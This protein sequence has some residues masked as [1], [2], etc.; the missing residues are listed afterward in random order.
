M[1]IVSPCFLM[2]FSNYIKQ[3][4]YFSYHRTFINKHFLSDL[5]LIQTNGQYEFHDHNIVSLPKDKEYWNVTVSVTAE[6]DAYIVLCEGRDPFSS[7][8]YWIILGG[9]Y[10]QIERCVIRRCPYGVNRE[11]N[12][13][14]PC[15]TPVDTHNVSINTK[16]ELMCGTVAVSA[17]GGYRQKRCSVSVIATLI[18]AGS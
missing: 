12:P 7:A 18:Q 6:H 3:L 17:P 15:S 4:R 9:W 5:P 16:R 1:H 2:V 11:R 13:E 8:C 10:G 14:E